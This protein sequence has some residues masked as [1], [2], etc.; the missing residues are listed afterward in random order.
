MPM[1][2]A[3]I[4]KAV[5]DIEKDIKRREGWIKTAV[6]GEMYFTKHLLP[7]HHH[8]HHTKAGCGYGME[9]LHRNIRPTWKKSSRAGY[10]PS[11]HTTSLPYY[12]NHH[13]HT[14]HIP[15]I[16]NGGGYIRFEY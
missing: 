6:W 10:N 16:V 15:S 1:P 14:H 9:N 7:N 12:H 5:E 4:R 11:P 8:N 2:I 3:L 13:Y